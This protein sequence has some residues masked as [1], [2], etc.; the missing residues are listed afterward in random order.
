M[1]TNTVDIL[2]DLTQTEFLELIKEVDKCLYLSKKEKSTLTTSPVAF[3]V[4][5]IPFV[6]NQDNPTQKAVL[7]LSN[8]IIA[9]RNTSLFSHKK[10]LT[11]RE[12]IDFGIVES[13][14]DRDI[15]EAYKLFLELA[16]LEDHKHDIDKDIKT[17]HPNPLIHNEVKYYRAKNKIYR[18][19]YSISPFISKIVD[20]GY[21][22]PIVTGFWLS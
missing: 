11:I 3:A 10:G 1:K 8:L 2:I 20:K 17:G 22:D 21:F 4:A 6:S 7:S 15:V 12:R 13:G 18:N 16:S 19:L 9:T 14:G 5:N